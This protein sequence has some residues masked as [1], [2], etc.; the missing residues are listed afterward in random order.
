MHAAPMQMQATVAVHLATMREQLLVQLQSQ[1]TLTQ[2]LKC[3]QHLRALNAYNDVD[4]RYVFLAVRY[5][6][7]TLIGRGRDATRGCTRRSSML[8]NR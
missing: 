3:V 6:R 7:P 2:C 4:M 5:C 1:A 8:C